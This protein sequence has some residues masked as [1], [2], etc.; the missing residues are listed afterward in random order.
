M[1]QRVTAC[2]CVF[3]FTMEF[4]SLLGLAVVGGLLVVLYWVYTFAVAPFRML[5]RCGIQGPPAVPFYGN[6]R[7]V[8]KMGRLKFTGEMIRKYGP[9]YGY[10]IFRF[11]ATRALLSFVPLHSL[12]LCSSV[13]YW[14]F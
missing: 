3:V 13:F 9:V 14:C 5:A 10:V 2:G 1:R 12:M 7:A 8:V 11:N 4:G 6:Q